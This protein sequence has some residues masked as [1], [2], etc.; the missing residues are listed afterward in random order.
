MQYACIRSGNGSRRRLIEIDLWSICVEPPE[1]GP[2]TAIIDET[3][4]TIVVLIKGVNAGAD[5]LM[6]FVSNMATEKNYTYGSDEKR[7]IQHAL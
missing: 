3:T 6:S 4:T 7:S 1:V 2:I 5:C